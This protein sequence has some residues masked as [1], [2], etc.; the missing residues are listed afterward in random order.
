MTRIVQRVA[1]VLAEPVEIPCLLEGMIPER[2]IVAIVAAPS[3]GKSLLTWDMCAHI[4]LGREWRGRTVTQ[5]PVLIVAGEGAAG[6]PGR[7]HAWCEEHD[8]HP[9]DFDGRLA[10]LRLPLDLSDSA[11]VARVEAELVELD[12]APR[13]LVFDTWS[14]CAPFG[15]D[16]S[17]TRDAKGLMDLMRQTRDRLQ[18]TLILVH[19]VG[20]NQER[21]RGSSDFRGAVDVLYLLKNDEG[22][23]TLTM[24]KARDLPPV[25]PLRF[26]VRSLGQS[27]GLEYLEGDESPSA[28]DALGP[29]HL[30]LLTVL[31]ECG[32]GEPLRARDI[33][34]RSGH[35]QSTFYRL[36]SDL[37]R[38][39]HMAKDR[40]GYF[41][42]RAGDDLLRGNSHGTPNALSRDSLTLSLPIGRESE[43]VSRGSQH[44]QSSHESPVGI[45]RESGPGLQNYPWHALDPA[46]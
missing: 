16:E 36:A 38:S 29:S 3:A 5:V 10:L 23:R 35:P 45:L 39:G 14:A 27:V 41:L 24:S 8:V 6:L 43:R 2:S 20:H 31:A 13:L 9:D 18:A 34:H 40:R 17:S 22:L 32:M 15:F 11:M 30:Q 46:S 1:E 42:T 25:P 7:I 26:R 4:A 33:V 44:S 12:M 37:Q 21:E 19:H 28:H